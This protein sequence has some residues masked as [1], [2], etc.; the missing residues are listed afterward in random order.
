MRDIIR[1]YQFTSL[2]IRILPVNFMYRPQLKVKVA[3]R[4]QDRNQ[5]LD[6][7]IR[8]L[9]AQ[10]MFQLQKAMREGSWD[11]R[12]VKRMIM[13]EELPPQGYWIIITCK[14]LKVIQLITLRPCNHLQVQLALSKSRVVP[15]LS[16]TSWQQSPLYSTM[17]PWH[18]LWHHSP[19]MRKMT[20]NFDWVSLESASLSWKERISRASYSKCTVKWKALNP[21]T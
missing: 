15:C 14:L 18:L 9:C 3:G 19:L 8:V 11:G 7:N 1:C 12:K 6:K 10:Q 17:N 5:L 20:N 13:K 21:D 4:P 16:P 2:V